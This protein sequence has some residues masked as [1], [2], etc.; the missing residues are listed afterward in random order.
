MTISPKFLNRDAA[1]VYLADKWGLRV[2][3][4]TLAK[5]AT[6][7]GGPPF[8][9]DGR[10]PVYPEPGL[11]AWAQQRLGPEVRSTSEYRATAA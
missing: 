2:A 10:F 3:K 6:L 4:A 1:S 5:Y 7:G 11:D 9:R 8:H